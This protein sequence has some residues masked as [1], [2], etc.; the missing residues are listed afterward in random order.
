[1]KS[2]RIQLPRRAGGHAGGLVPPARRTVRVANITISAEIVCA[3]WEVFAL[4]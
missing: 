1:M 4:E 2:K 3:L